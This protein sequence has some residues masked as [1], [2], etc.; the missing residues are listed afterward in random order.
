MT[1]TVG[2][3]AVTTTVGTGAV[4]TTASGRP[5]ASPAHLAGRP[6]LAGDGRATRD[7]GVVDEDDGV[8]PDGVTATDEEF[9]GVAALDPALL[10]AL[11]E[12]SADASGDGVRLVVNSGWRSARYQDRLRAEAVSRYGSQEEAAR[13]VATAETSA[14]VS[15]DAVDVGPTGAARWL[16]EHGARYGLCRTYENE[17]WH[18][19]LRPGAV[20]GGCPPAYAD[21]SQDPRMRR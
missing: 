4:T 13:W 11:R 1:A 9:P 3:G 17:P 8:L 18:F 14:H 2:T 10:R 16:A 19:E 7:D 5:A 20:G 6:P 12:A 21:P 15:G